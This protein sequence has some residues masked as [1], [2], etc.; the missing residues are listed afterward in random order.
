[1]IERKESEKVVEKHGK[2]VNQNCIIIPCASV[3]ATS[4]DAP[5]SRVS[6]V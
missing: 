6:F 3:R 1:M 5:A 4:I 2:A